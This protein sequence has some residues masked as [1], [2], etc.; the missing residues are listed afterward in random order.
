MLK[1]IELFA[2]I[3]SQTQALKNIG[4]PH[5]VIAISEIDKY[6][7]RSYEALHGAVNNL[8]D[9][10]E[11]QELPQ[12][13]LWTYSFPC[14]TA[15][16][17]VLTDGGYKRISEI[18]DGDL[19]LTHKNRYRKV[20][21]FREQGKKEILK[22]K[23]M[24]FDEIKCTP[25]H[26]FY[27]R[28]RYCKH[29]HNPN[30][31]LRLFKP[32]EWVEAKEL[33]KNHYLGLAINQNSIVPSWDGIS[34]LWRDGRR[35]RN[36]NQ[37][38]P[39]MENKNFWWVIGRYVGDGWQRTQDGIII[40]GAYDEREEIAAKLDG[41]FHYCVSEE[42]TVIKFHIPLKELGKF[43][44]QF[45]KGS[46][47]LR[48]TNT[49]LDLPQDLLEAFLDGYISAD[50]CFTNG[51]FKA[52]SVSRELIYG[53][54]QCIAKVYRRPFSIYKWNRP[55]TCVIEGREVN[56]RTVYEIT[57][58]KTTDKQDNA[59]YEDGCI[60]FPFTSIEDCGTV[61][62]YDISVDEDE[63]FTANGVIA[64]NCTDIS[65][66]GKQAGLY[67]G[68]R[69]GL[70][71]EVE[72]L[73]IRAKESGTLPKLL[74]LENVKNL[75]GKNFKADYDKWL[76]FLSELGY[77]NYWQVLN[78][79]HYG[80]PQN[81]ERVFCVSARGGHTP[82]Q[83]PPKQELKL[84]LKD[85]IDVCVDERYYLKDSTIKGMLNSAYHQR[86]DSIW[87][88]DDIVNTLMARDFKGPQCVKVGELTGGKWDKIHEHCRRVY[89]PDG[90]SPTLHCAGGGNTEPKII[91]DFYAERPPRV[92]DDSSPAL[93][94]DRYGLKVVAGQ[95]QP[96]DRD[97]NK[98]GGMRE[99]QFERRRDELA[100][101]VL[102]GDRKNCVQIAAMRGRNP[103]NPSDGMAEGTTEQRL[104]P[105]KEGVC[106]ALTTVRK[107]NLVIEAQVLTMQRSEYGRAVR[108]A[109]EAGEIEGSRRDMKE[110]VPRDDGM[111]NTLTTV[112]ADNL[113]LLENNPHLLSADA[114]VGRTVRV[115]GHGDLQRH[116]W[117]VIKIREATQKGYAEAHFG[118]GVN[119]QYPNSTTARGRVA[120][121]ISNTLMCGDGR[122]IVTDD[123]RIRKLTPR[124]CLRL[125]GWH[126]EQI[127]KIEA[128]GISNAQK[129]R[130]AG[131]GIVVQVL[132]AI[133]KNLFSELTADGEL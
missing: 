118:D 66:A 6:A 73:L 67:G 123:I 85:M 53:I 25:Q 99:E 10:R 5:G 29:L 15:D 112:Q 94:S 55:K 52:T 90:L 88:G 102:T 26:R 28:E 49:V 60:W 95:F 8:G 13:D 78:A 41:M 105:N 114:E 35:A 83:F 57:F 125:M 117:D 54:G 43:V 61:P 122:G 7:L 27:V 14:F 97:Y 133:F 34:F 86:R 127:D 19:V 1:V 128:A 64:H 84:R 2:G 18:K 87:G 11:I 12:A 74:L 51:Q 40:C 107:D 42:R 58:K 82:Y 108:K 63:S 69:S 37:L 129:Y 33:K 98:H 65:L 81:R 106:N 103:E 116:S 71:W 30:R 91:D 56:R 36:K 131:N 32:P 4:V 132:E 46:A 96:V 31:E 21:E 124:E 120:K 47:N 113:V 109:Y 3:G 115:G 23:G 50:G 93:R 24:A 48:L 111:A 68:T 80:I 62:V 9:I 16:T 72:R 70:L 39:L 79:K 101:A 75:V 126:D 104:E 17:L 77:T 121:G 110:Y 20:T 44:R 100:N 38:A 59:F 22:I 89:E 92:F 119:T 45:G 130:Q 76:A